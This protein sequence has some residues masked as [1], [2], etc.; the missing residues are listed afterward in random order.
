MKSQLL[1]SLYLEYLILRFSR[2]YTDIYPSNIW[3]DYNIYE[4]DII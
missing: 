2:T 1:C 3:T 4:R